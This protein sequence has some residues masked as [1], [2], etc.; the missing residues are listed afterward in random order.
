ML[1]VVLVAG[2]FIYNQS[3]LSS[4][5]TGSPSCAPNAPVGHNYQ[6]TAQ[7]ADYAQTA[8][9]S[10][11]SLQVAIA[12]AMAESAGD[13]N[14]YN[15]ELTANPVP[16]SGMGS[17]GLWQIYLLQHPEFQGMNLYDP[18]INAN[19]AYSIYNSAG[20]S[21]SPWSTFGSTA[22]MSF[23]SQAGDQISSMTTSDQTV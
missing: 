12:I 1:A 22:F 17:Y 10:G 15:P 14:A 19:A 3:T 2:W 23:L 4:G 5:S 7:I 18:Q 6:S 13:A 9:F 21:F 20:Q 11:D 16:P 8:G